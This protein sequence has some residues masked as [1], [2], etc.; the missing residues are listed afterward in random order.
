[1][2][3]LARSTRWWVVWLFA[4]FL[5]YEIPAIIID[6]SHTLSWTIWSFMAL[7]WAAEWAV[8]L[9]LAWL[10]WHFTVDFRNWREH[11]KTKRRFKT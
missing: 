9:L 3:W 4:G 7:H 5:A 2:A 10:V 8:Y 6:P 11:V 1:M